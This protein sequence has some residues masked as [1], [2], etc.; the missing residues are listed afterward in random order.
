[1][2]LLDHAQLQQLILCPALEKTETLITMS[3]SKTPNGALSHKETNPNPSFQPLEF[4]DVIQHI[5]YNH[6]PTKR[7]W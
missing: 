2:Q 4:G 5:C 6:K 3:S 1:L 7:R